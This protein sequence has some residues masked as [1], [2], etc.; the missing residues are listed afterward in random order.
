MLYC[1]ASLWFYFYAFSLRAWSGSFIWVFRLEISL[2]WQ[3]VLL[4]P[5]TS[6]VFHIFYEG[7][8]FLFYHQRIFSSCTWW[9]CKQPTTLQHHPSSKLVIFF[10]FTF[11][12]GMLFWCLKRFYISFKKYVEVLYFCTSRSILVDLAG[13]DRQSDCDC[14]KSYQKNSG[15]QF[16]V[17]EACNMWQLSSSQK[18]FG[19]H[20]SRWSG[21][22]RSQ[23]RSPKIDP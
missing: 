19:M 21:P 17:A 15:Q 7:Y 2:L 5:L 16:K 10:K 23:A 6:A 9:L 11:I 3:R 12:F 1:Y 4:Y 20:K 8:S 13:P 18:S 22:A 14:M